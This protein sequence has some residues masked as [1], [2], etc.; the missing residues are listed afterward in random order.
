MLAG[1]SK[2][3][4]SVVPNEENHLLTEVVT[5]NTTEKEDSVD[6]GM[7]HYT[8]ENIASAEEYYPTEPDFE[9]RGDIISDEFALRADKTTEYMGEDLFQVGIHSELNQKNEEYREYLATHDIKGLR[10]PMPPPKY[11]TVIS[12]ISDY[13]G[14]ILISNIIINKGQSC[15]LV[16]KL[17]GVMHYGQKLSG[18]TSCDQAQVR[19]I[20]IY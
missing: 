19:H 2:D 16:G 4:N 6:Y 18:R 13:D 17:N 10:P 1:C 20:F 11:D 15:R 8:D 5:A 12:I 14:E 7:G 3:N 9:E